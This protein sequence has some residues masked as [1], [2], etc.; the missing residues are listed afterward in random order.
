MRHTPHLLPLLLAL[1][2]MSH[3]ATRVDVYDPDDMGARDINKEYEMVLHENI[4]LLLPNDSS[5]FYHSSDYIFTSADTDTPKNLT[6][7]GQNDERGEVL[8]NCAATFRHLGV[9]SFTFWVNTWGGDKNDASISALGGA[10]SGG[11]NDSFLFQNNG[12]ILFSDIIYDSSEWGANHSNISV[13]GGAIHTY[14]GHSERVEFSHN[15][16]VTLQYISIVNIHDTNYCYKDLTA[17]GGAIYTNNLQISD[18]TNSVS[19]YNN[20]IHQGVC[21]DVEGVGKGGAAYII[22]SLDISANQRNVVL[23][24]NSILVANTAEGGALY[25]TENSSGKIS[26]NLQHIQFGQNK[27]QAAT[28][29]D[30]N[31]AEDSLAATCEARGGAIYIGSQLL[32]ERNK[33]NITIESNS[34]T[35]DY[36]K[37]LE[38]GRSDEHD[39]DPAYALGG[40]IFLANGAHLGI[41]YNGTE[42][43]AAMGHVTFSG[44]KVY[45][46]G[47]SGGKAQGG[48]VFLSSDAELSISNNTGDV[49]FT[50][51]KATDGGAIYFSANSKGSIS[52][53]GKVS[54][55]KNSATYGAG[56]FAA[57]YT[58]L[59]HNEHVTFQNNIA[60]AYG[61]GVFATD[62]INLSFNE[63]VTFQ[64]NIATEYGAGIYTTSQVLING[65][66]SVLFS[67][68]EA[69]TGSA[70]YA[71]SGSLV[72]IYSNN[73]E[74]KFTNNEL[75]TGDPSSGAI[76]LCND[77]TLKLRDN[78][79]V[80]FE[81][82]EFRRT[83][84]YGDSGSSTY[85]CGNKTVT[86]SEQT[87]MQT[88]IQTAGA[89]YLHDTAEAVELINNGSL[90]AYGGVFALKGSSAL[91][92]V[93]GNSGSI[94]A[95]GNYVSRAGGV[96][97]ADE[98]SRI[99]ICDNADVT[100]TDNS[101]WFG[102]AAIDSDGSIHIRNNA[103]RVIFGNNSVYDEESKSTTLCSLRADNAQFSAATGY[104]I[105][106]R[107]SINIFSEDKEAP[108]LV[109]NADYTDS[110][111]TTHKQGGDIIFTGAD[112]INADESI[113][114]EASRHSKINGDTTLHNGRLIV[115][116]QAMLEGYT[117]STTEHSGASVVLS[118]GGYLNQSAV[119]IATGTTLQAGDADTAILLADS[120]M[121]V[122]S[123]QQLVEN[124]TV[125]GYF[126]GSSL[127]LQNGST[128]AMYGGI[129]DLYG[130]RLTLGAGTGAITLCS[131]LAPTLIG[132]EYILLLFTGVNNLIFSEGSED[133][134]FIYNGREY[135]AE[136]LAYAANERAVYLRNVIIPEPATTTLCFLA[137]AALI[138]R[139]R[140]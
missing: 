6:F 85:I 96:I 119:N 103:G 23:D 35:A 109:L 66:G 29:V 94:T 3:G 33:G 17:L 7:Y 25:L 60:T 74:V 2:T 127:N 8:H 56:V 121:L 128:Y 49:Y 64:N 36:S 125:C 72:D 108:I 104:S 97:H 88:I 107:D 45:T 137:L 124:T 41:N 12:A 93:C 37:V 76:H 118:Q 28:D 32:I 21:T 112:T 101:S 16:S 110:S 9:V 61:A 98:G 53:N 4:S 43:N 114:A 54:F 84:L 39:N 31:F 20:R 71:T 111:G 90:D 123:L 100:I 70:I 47:T 19:L 138:S 11:D 62:Y 80:I 91:L 27:V 50:F 59:S 57:G 140:R 42:G 58:D 67:G 46:Y 26:D 22:N 44:N 55:E 86:I 15:A 95:K 120:P 139:R 134:R 126:G 18:T 117:L 63:H 73:G 40:A 13:H 136:Q 1:G 82:G 132:D 133:I 92:S 99:L 129:L 75:S 131:T 5:N 106:F 102:A 30:F 34:A 14:A 10:I 78:A 69:Q 115:T 81:S 52:N 24:S 65:N 38:N 83:V 130:G 135:G 68:N 77:A 113:N 116:Q 79:A 87:A 89:L 48:A 122:E 51:N 105:E